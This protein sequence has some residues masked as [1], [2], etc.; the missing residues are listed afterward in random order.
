MC[1]FFLIKISDFG[2]V[3][4]EEGMTMKSFLKHLT[5]RGNIS[6]IPPETFTQST[7]PPGTAFDV[8]RWLAKGICKKKK[9]APS[10]SLVFLIQCTIHNSHSVTLL[11]TARTYTEYNIFL[12]DI[13]Y[14]LLRCDSLLPSQVFFNVKMNCTFPQNKTF[15]SRCLIYKYVS[16]LWTY[17]K[18]EREY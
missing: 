4:W 18:Q 6:Y 5:E 9:K 2:L 15:F 12:S 14:V 13:F 17:N 10:E 11:C 8:Y 16:V 3:S 1:L 7:D